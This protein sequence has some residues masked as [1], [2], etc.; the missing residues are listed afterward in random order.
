MLWK[1]SWLDWFK[2]Y[3]NELKINFLQKIDWTFRNKSG[4][5]AIGDNVF[6]GEAEDN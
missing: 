5:K 4:I 3:V 2:Q 1:W 6:V